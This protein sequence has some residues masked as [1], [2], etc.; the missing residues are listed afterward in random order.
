MGLLWA[1]LRGRVILVS[2]VDILIFTIGQDR[3]LQT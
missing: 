2:A 3:E 1:L